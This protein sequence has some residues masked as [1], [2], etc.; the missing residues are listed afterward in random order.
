MD[1][2]E[3][4]HNSHI[5]A[6]VLEVIDWNQS[7]NV[8]EISGERGALTGVLA[9]RS[10]KVTSL[11][12]SVEDM[13]LNQ[14]KNATCENI[15]YLQGNLNEKL[16]GLEE[17]YD[18]IVS[19]VKCDVTLEDLLREADCL[20]APDG[21]ILYVCENR[22]GMRY[23]SGAQSE[24]EGGFFAGIEEGKNALKRRYTAGE[25]QSVLDVEEQFDAQW[26]YPY[27]DQIYPLS[28]HSAKYLPKV[29]ELNNNGIL[30]EHARLL[31][32]NEAKAYDVMLQEGIYGE[33]ANAFLL[34]ITRR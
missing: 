14:K 30:S 26:Y 12:A 4:Y 18:V 29:G 7:I 5:R 6:N 16:A 11:I 34:V 20:L 15:T 25:L 10:A 32:Y 1:A 31:L 13:A 22:L 24:P 27:P 9:E 19:I 33:F 3:I 8:L 2:N 21:K 28:I 17:S 23:L